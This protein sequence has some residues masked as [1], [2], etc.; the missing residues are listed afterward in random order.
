MPC[1]YYTGNK[2]SP[3]D[4]WEVVRYCLQATMTEEEIEKANLELPVCY[5]SRR[6]A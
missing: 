4:L 2:K 6:E 3:C 1:E 5:I